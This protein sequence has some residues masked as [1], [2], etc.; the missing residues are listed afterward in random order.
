MDNPPAPPPLTWLNRMRMVLVISVN[1]WFSQRDAS[2]G[3]ALAYYSLFSMAPILLLV[4]AIA[5]AVFGHDAAQ[6]QLFGQLNQ[7]VGPTGAQAIQMI[8]ANT[9]STGSGVAATLFASVLLLVGATTVFTELKDSLDE[10]W[11]IPK[12]KN[13]IG[14]FGILRARLLSFGMVLV[15]A[16]LLLISLVVSSLLVIVEKFWAGYWG[17]AAW[18]LSPVA[19]AFSF[20]VVAF[21]FAVIY[22]MLPQIRLSWGDVWVGAVGTAVLFNLGKY[23][24]GTYL[25][26]SGLASSYG[27]AGSIVALLLWVYYSAQIFFLGAE[28]TRQYALWFGSLR[29]ADQAPLAL[30]ASAKAAE[31]LE[32][33]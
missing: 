12:D 5:G 19:T 33:E 22:K 29:E 18:I 28:F 6:G 26:H 11:H 14:F 32:S 30:V 16:F 13:S 7:L 24:I 10:I 3:A 25:V 17:P 4:I 1:E 21:L 9:Q 15:L 2:K 20:G 27:A 23:A 8:L 31:K